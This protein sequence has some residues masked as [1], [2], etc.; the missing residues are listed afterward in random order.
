MARAASISVLMYLRATQACSPQEVR[1]RLIESRICSGRSPQN[2]QL[3][4]ITSNA[5]R[6]PNPARAPNPPAA[7]MA[8]S[9]SVRNLSQIRSFIEIPPQFVIACVRA[10]S[11][12]PWHVYW[13]HPSTHRHMPPIEGSA[14]RWRRSPS[15]SLLPLN[16]AIFHSAT[17]SIWRAGLPYHRDLEPDFGHKAVARLAVA[18]AFS[19][20][21]WRM[22]QPCYIGW[23]GGT[24]IS[25]GRSFR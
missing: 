8:L 5:G 16:S 7:N 6:L 3:T 1:Q 2:A 14:R 21:E 12:P 22:I 24:P 20:S 13:P 4:S 11:A 25:G 15:S 19:W 17:P 10:R 9:R 18:A 23:D